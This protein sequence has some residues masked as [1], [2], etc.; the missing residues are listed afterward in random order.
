MWI[1]SVEI[2]DQFHDRWSI[3]TFIGVLDLTTRLKTK[4]DHHIA[5]KNVKQAR[6]TSIERQ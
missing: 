5:K 6:E 3:V 1:T 4:R 2:R